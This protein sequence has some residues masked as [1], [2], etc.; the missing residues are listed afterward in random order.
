MIL[1]HPMRMKEYTSLV[2]TN[3]VVYFI[4]LTVY[5]V[6]CRMNDGW[7]TGKSLKLNGFCPKRSSIELFAAA[8]FVK[9]RQTLARTNGKST[10]V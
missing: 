3:R 6:Y 10:E 2:V 5:R 9:P 4:T 1:E 8:D 7:R